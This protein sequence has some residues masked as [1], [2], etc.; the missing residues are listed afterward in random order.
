MRILSGSP[1]VFGL[2]LIWERSTATSL[3]VRRLF[4][5]IPLTLDVGTVFSSAAAVLQQPP[6]PPFPGDHVLVG[7]IC[8]YGCHYVGYFLNTVNGEWTFID[9]TRVHRFGTWGNVVS[10][11]ANG[12]HMPAVLFYVL[13]AEAHG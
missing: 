12:C 11:S 4:S 1:G 13:S 6:G 8:F 3:E 5:S 10:R 2:V 9:D 7:L